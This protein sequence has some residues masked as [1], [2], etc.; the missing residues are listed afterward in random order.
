LREEEY[1][2]H[3]EYDS[4]LTRVRLLAAANVVAAAERLHLH[5]NE[6]VELADLKTDLKPL[7]ADV[8]AFE[9]KRSKTVEPNKT[10]SVLR[11]QL[12]DSIQ[13]PDR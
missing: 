9:E 8:S 1:A 10:C 7:V 12:W 4:M 3:L 5:D 6:L 2:L 11:G 13:G